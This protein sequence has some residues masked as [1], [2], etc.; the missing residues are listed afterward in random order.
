M[1]VEG[2]AL[3]GTALDAVEGTTVERAMELDASPDAVWDAVCD[4]IG[5]LA[6]AGWLDVRPGG[7][8][9]L[10]DDGV[11]RD[12]AVDDVEPGRRLAYR[13]WTRDEGPGGASRVE[14]TVLP[15]NDTTRLIIRESRPAMAPAATLRWSVRSVCL[16]SA[17]LSL[18]MV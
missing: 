9:H 11:E 6:D 4:P 17:V 7:H 5:W 8:G 14:I 1:D 13:W 18:S 15:T 2:T 10:I 12:V 16:A 3:D